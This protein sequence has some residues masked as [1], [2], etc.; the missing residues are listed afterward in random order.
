MPSAVEADDIVPKSVED[1]FL[2]I[3]GKHVLDDGQA[4]ER[5]E[6]VSPSGDGDELLFGCV[7]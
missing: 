4:A 2:L 5:A 1:L 3:S 6:P 7:E